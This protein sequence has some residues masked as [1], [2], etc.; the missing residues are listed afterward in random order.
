MIVTHIGV[1]APAMPRTVVTH[2]ALSARP[3]PP[4][5][6]MAT[7]ASRTSVD[8]IDRQDDGHVDDQKQNPDRHHTESP[9]LPW[10]APCRSG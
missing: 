7:R 1:V 3:D 4:G 9:A 6:I 10:D 8:E 2:R 5:R